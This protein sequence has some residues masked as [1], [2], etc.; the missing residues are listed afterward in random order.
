VRENSEAHDV[1]F[2]LRE[3]AAHI[4]AFIA[5][6]ASV[7]HDWKGIRPSEGFFIFA[8]LARDPPARILE[9]GRGR[10]YSTEILARSFPA[11]RVISIDSDRHSPDVELAAKRLGAIRNV[12]CKFGDARLEL[13]RLIQQDDCILIDGP[14]DFRALKLAFR[15]LRTGEPRAVFLHDAGTGSRIRNFLGEQVPSALFSNAPEF[16]RLYGFVGTSEPRPAPGEAVA[17]EVVDRLSPGAMAYLPLERLN[18]GRLLAAVILRQWKER[19]HDTFQK[20]LRRAK[21]RSKSGRI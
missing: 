19:L 8:L 2:L 6:T 11:A 12:E 9:S 14:K 18:Y 7:V 21:R 17:A 10:G 20:F 5:R 13:P 16:L 3:A 1:S 15:L 4:D